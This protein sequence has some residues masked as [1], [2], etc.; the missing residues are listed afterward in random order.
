MSNIP[1]NIKKMWEEAAAKKIID[2]KKPL[3]GGKES[4][5]NTGPKMVKYGEPAKPSP[6]AAYAAKHGKGGTGHD[7]E[8]ENP[9]LYKRNL[10][11]HRG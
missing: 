6:R 3:H 8:T 11:L 9:A 7:L 5:P 1:N 4:L 2:P 10:D